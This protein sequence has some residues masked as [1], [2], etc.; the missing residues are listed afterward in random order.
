M[1]WLSAGGAALKSFKN[2]SGR[3]LFLG[4]VERI[5]KFTSSCVQGP[6]KFA[7]EKGRKIWLCDRVAG[8]AVSSEVL[9]ELL[10]RMQSSGVRRL[11]ILIGGPDGFSKEQIKNLAPDF[12]WSFGPLTYPHELAAVVAAEQI[13]RALTIQRHLPYHSGHT[14]YG[15]R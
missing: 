9:A 6:L 7:G 5:S 14:S 13:Y 8:K 1:D 10:E 2:E 3:D 12:I 15:K 4:Y 11:G